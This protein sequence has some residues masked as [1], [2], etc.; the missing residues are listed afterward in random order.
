MGIKESIENHPTKWIASF[1]AAVV[2]V[3]IGIED[4]YAKAGDIKEIKEAV[5]SN[6]VTMDKKVQTIVL[7]NRKLSL[8]DKVIDLEIKQEETRLNSAEKRQLL[9]YKN[10]LDDANRELRRLER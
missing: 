4:R 9:R 6:R 10:E 1:V 3:T 2:L 8:E 7:K 5:E